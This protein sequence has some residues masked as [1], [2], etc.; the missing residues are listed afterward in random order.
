MIDELEC[1][2]YRFAGRDE[3]CLSAGTE[4][5]VQVLLIPPLFDEMNRMRRMMVDVMRML[6]ERDVGTILPDLPGTNE[7]LFPQEEASLEIWTTALKSCLGIHE[8]CTFI[9]S[10]RGGCLIDDISD[11]LPIW[12]LTP[13]KGKSLL[14]TMMR[15]RIA[16]D[17]EIGITIGMSDLSTKVKTETIELAGNIVARLMFEQLEEAAPKTPNSL[18][19]ARLHADSQPSDVK[20]DGNPLWLRAEPDEDTLLS[21]SIADDLKKWIG[22]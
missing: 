19:T 2:S 15:T 3:Y 8:K 7:S 21:Q 6:S 16:A 1:S 12:R 5:N 13:V 9:A 17:R 14:R 11:E 18:R 10:F 22:S 20:L 4:H